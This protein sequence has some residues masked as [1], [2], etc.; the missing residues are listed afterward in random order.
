M[1]KFAKPFIAVV[2]CC[3]LTIA[4]PLLAQN[5]TN[6]SAAQTADRNEDDN[7]GKWG[8]AGL[9]GLIGLAGLRRRDDD[10]RTRVS[11]NP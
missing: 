1:K 6:T 3:S 10:N 7:T 9:L 8:L 2:L 5:E 11:R 4:T